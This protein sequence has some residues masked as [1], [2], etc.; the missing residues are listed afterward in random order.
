M[1]SETF[2]RQLE[3][4]SDSDWQE[5]IDGQ[6]ILN[7][8]DQVFIIG[9]A[10]APNAIIRAEDDVSETVESLKHSTL[11]QA[12]DIL[13][14]YYLTHPVTLKGFNAQVQRLIKAH[15][16][17]AFAA[18]EGSFPRYTLF[19]EGGEVVAEPHTSPRHR[20]GVFCELDQAALR[21]PV[22]DAVRRWLEYGEA[23]ERYLEMNVCRYNC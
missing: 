18:H 16:A 11:E 23:H 12:G 6:A 5:V 8:D 14:N 1:N 7:I 4:L 17:E 22:N 13:R 10:S 21:Q 15:G 9:K 3:A 20:Y 19:V 2:I